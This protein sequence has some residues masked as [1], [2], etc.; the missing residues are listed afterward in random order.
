MIVLYG[1]SDD[2]AN[3]EP[4]IYGRG[5]DRDAALADACFKYSAM[6]GGDHRNCSYAELTL[7][8]EGCLIAGV[9]VEFVVLREEENDVDGLIDVNLSQTTNSSR[10]SV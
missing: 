7:A 8:A 1:Y 2:P 4:L 5:E 6:A 3:S 9:D 10:T